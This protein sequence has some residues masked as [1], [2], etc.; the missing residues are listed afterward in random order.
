M[1]ETGHGVDAGLAE[2]AVDDTEFHSSGG[3]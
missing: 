1:L 3:V 2:G